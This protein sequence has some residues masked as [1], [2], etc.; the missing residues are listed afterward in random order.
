MNTVTQTP[1]VR[2]R[3][4]HA[5]KLGPRSVGGITYELL[6]DPQRERL[7]IAIVGN[8]SSG[9]WSREVV[10]ITDVEEAIASAG[11]EPFPTRRLAAAFVGR[12]VN[13]AGFI[14]AALAHERLIQPA[15]GVQH[16]VVVVGDWAAWRTAALAIEGEPIL[17]PPVA[18]GAPED[19]VASG[20]ANEPATGDSTIAESTEAADSASGPRRGRKGKDGDARDS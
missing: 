6:A 20:T 12:S 14:A 8:D 10:P 9:C 17:V 11:R 3:R 16:H 19:N 15:P 18:P 4:E 5:R 7:F 13:N 1:Y 2:L